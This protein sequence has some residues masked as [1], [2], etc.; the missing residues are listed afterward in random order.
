M[1]HGI[2]VIPSRKHFVP[3]NRSKNHLFV[4][5]GVPVL[6]N[7][8]ATM[9]VYGSGF[10]NQIVGI[11][12][13][14]PADAHIV[15]QQPKSYTREEQYSRGVGLESMQ[16]TGAPHPEAV[17]RLKQIIF[18]TKKKNHQQRDNIKFVV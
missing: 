11:A 8:V 2:V 3:F 9:P 14:A 18:E 15:K 1:R 17:N 12:S 16:S 4:G 10:A 5:G 6:L 13:P 7:K